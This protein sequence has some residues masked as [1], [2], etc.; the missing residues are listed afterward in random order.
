MAV[1]VAGAAVLSGC[2]TNVDTPATFAATVTVTGEADE[3]WADSGECV[4]AGV[5]HLVPGYV[6]TISAGTGATTSSAS[7]MVE[8]IEPNPVNGSG[9]CTYT[10][11]FGAIAANQRSYELWVSNNVRQQS[12]TADQLKGGALYRLEGASP[13]SDR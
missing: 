9:T 10:A 8:S 13:R 5:A 7:L 4:W 6:V 3:V 11:Y 12:F 1:T 2:V